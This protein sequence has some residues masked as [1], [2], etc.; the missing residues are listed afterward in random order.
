[1]E[2]LTENLTNIE[3][4]Q[5]RLHSLAVDLGLEQQEENDETIHLTT[6]EK[7]VNRGKLEE[8]FYRYNFSHFEALCKLGIFLE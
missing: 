5:K 3:E 8:Y 1:M 7:P 6:K 2:I 4:S